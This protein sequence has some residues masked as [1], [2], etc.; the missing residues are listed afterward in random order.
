MQNP[1][2]L[3]RPYAA[4]ANI[5]AVLARVRTRNL[6][7]RIDDDLL[8]LAGT[9]A[10]AIHRVRSAIRFLGLT[11]DA[12]VPT[13]LLRSLAGAPD[14]QYRQL[15]EGAIRDAYGRDFERVN[16]SE[17]SQAQI[18]NAFQRYTPRSQTNRMVIL[19]LGL[20]REAGIPVSD[21]PRER[22]MA[23]PQAR[24]QRGTPKQ[25][26][27]RGSGAEMQKGR[28]T[29]NSPAD[30][31]GPPP[32]LLFGLTLEDAAALPQDDFE[33]VWSVLGK[34]IRARAQRKAAP[35]GAAEADDDDDDEGSGDA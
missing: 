32:G 11:D 8:R 35:E 33:E 13:D 19:F 21:A 34:V 12:D 14:E 18:V 27:A 6:P 30:G 28:A 7:E 20:C 4:P 24:R 17:D 16:P 26:S 25:P 23:S 5:I 3:A 31:P 9:P 1:A 15:L 2:D 29:G 10:G 22:S